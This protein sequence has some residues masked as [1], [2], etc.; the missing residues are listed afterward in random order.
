ME[1]GGGECSDATSQTTTVTDFPGHE[2]RTEKQK[3]VR[4]AVSKT[5]QQIIL[6][7]GVLTKYHTRPP[8]V[9]SD[10]YL[11]TYINVGKALYNYNRQACT[12]LAKRPK[13]W[14]TV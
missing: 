8:P 6:L 10:T 4:G 13:N 1:I 7:I 3:A 14:K 5:Q 12:L 2:Q 11:G 9:Y